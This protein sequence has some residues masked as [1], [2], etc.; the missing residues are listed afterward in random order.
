MEPGF[1]DRDVLGKKLRDA[2]LTMPLTDKPPRIQLLGKRR[3]RKERRQRLLRAERIRHRDNERALVLWLLR[4]CGILEGMRCRKVLN[5]QR[6]FFDPV[7]SEPR[8]SAASN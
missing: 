6:E 5:S 1:T 2:T 7:T 4:G 8:E 3:G